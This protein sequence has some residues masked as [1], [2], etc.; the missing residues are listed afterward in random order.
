[1]K[2]NI[3]AMLLVLGLLAFTVSGFADNSKKGGNYDLLFAKAQTIIENMADIKNLKNLSDT[4]KVYLSDMY[5]LSLKSGE[6]IYKPENISNK[7]SINAKEAIVIVD[8]TVKA[9]QFDESKT[10]YDI[11]SHLTSVVV[12]K[13]RDVYVLVVPDVYQGIQF[14]KLY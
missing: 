5:V 7:T 1:M 6:I 11:G 14:K 4:E 13:S 10:V 9:W 8:K 12:T 3:I 2:K